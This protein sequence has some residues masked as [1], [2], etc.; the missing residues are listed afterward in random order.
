MSEETTNNVSYTPNPARGCGHKR[1][2]GFYAEGGEIG[3]GGALNAFTWLLGDGL[4]HSP[5][6]IMTRIPPR[7]MVIGNTYAALLEGEFVDYLVPYEPRFED[8]GRLVELKKRV[9]PFA[10]F[11]HVGSNHYSPFS[12]AEECMKYGPSRRIPPDIAKMLLLGPEVKRKGK[13]GEAEKGRKEQREGGM[14]PIPII[15]THSKMPV[16]KSQAQKTEVLELAECIIDGYESDKKYHGATWQKEDWGLYAKFKDLGHDH[17]LPAILSIFHVLDNEWSR[18]KNSPL[19]QQAKEVL[20]KVE[21]V[22]QVFGA[23]WICQVS[24]VLPKDNEP[25]HD[26]VNELDGLNI[27][28]LSGDDN[29]PA[30]EDDEN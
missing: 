15:F 26:F 18:V 14:L 21:R 7:Q 1:P 30:G 3:I 5:H 25:V 20:G 12:F 23:S 10:I 19:W 4:A 17:Y 6:N 28:D 27:L 24:Y 13:A 16:F 2:G 29:Q 9:P 22:E 11:D 8:T